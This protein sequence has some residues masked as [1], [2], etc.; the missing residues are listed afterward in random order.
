MRAPFWAC[1]KMAL[2]GLTRT[3]DL[4]VYTRQEWV[5]PAALA[6]HMGLA[7]EQA[8]CL[9]LFQKVKAALPVNILALE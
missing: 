1:Q 9:H 5:G 2:V 7:T 8:S 3:G 6:W 4:L